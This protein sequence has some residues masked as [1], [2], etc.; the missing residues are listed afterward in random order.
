VSDCG[1]L[2]ALEAPAVVT[3]IIASELDGDFGLEGVA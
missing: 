3:S 1:I 2:A